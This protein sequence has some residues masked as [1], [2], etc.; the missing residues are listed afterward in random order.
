[1]RRNAEK[2]PVKPAKGVFEAKLRKASH[3]GCQ[4]FPAT[5]LWR[6]GLGRAMATRHGYS[7]KTRSWSQDT[8]IA[9]RQGRARIAALNAIGCSH[10]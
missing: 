9:T 2:L 6:S 3:T 7:H 8:V 10:R 5:L 1:M 4:E